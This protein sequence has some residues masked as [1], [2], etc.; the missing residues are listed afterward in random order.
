[1]IKNTQR[2]RNI[3]EI[4]QNLETQQP[5]SRRLIRAAQNESR[6]GRHRHRRTH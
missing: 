1:M 2:Q 3:R 5:R 6:G 4:K